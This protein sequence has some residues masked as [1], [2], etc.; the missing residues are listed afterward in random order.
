MDHIVGDFGLHSPQVASNLTNKTTYTTNTTINKI[1]NKKTETIQ[2]P[3]EPVK[4]SEPVKPTEPELVTK[5]GDSTTHK[6]PELEFNIEELVE[7]EFVK[8]FPGYPN[9]IKD[10][11]DFDEEVGY[12]YHISNDFE[13][14]E[15][16]N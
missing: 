11:V 2:T 9:I 16:Q 15:W 7:Q 1:I 8:N 10:S 14:V 6:V 13:V 5:N 3:T 12:N 4:P